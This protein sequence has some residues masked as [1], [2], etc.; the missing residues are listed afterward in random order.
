[1]PFAIFLNGAIGVGKTYLG[2]RLADRL[3]AQF[4]DTDDFRDR[5]FGWLQ[6][7][8]KNSQ[9]LLNATISLLEQNSVGIIA[10][11]LRER[12]W[13]FYETHFFRYDIKAYC[14]TLSAEFPH[15]VASNRGR[16]FSHSEKLRCKEMIAEGY[17]NRQFSDAIVPTD[18]HPVS[19]TL[20]L[21]E[22]LCRSWIK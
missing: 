13:T 5:S 15:I 20:D 22:K 2:K 10:C 4:I 14:I 7:N 21:L 9:R 3:N 8:Y 11:P 17:N 12:D 18:Q 6:D 19:E 1:M 16:I